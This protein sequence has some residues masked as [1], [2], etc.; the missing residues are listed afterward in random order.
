[1]RHSGGMPIDVTLV[2]AGRTVGALRD[3]SGGVFAAAGDFDRLLDQQRSLPL[4]S[5]IDP[6][7]TTRTRAG[8]MPQL[9]EELTGLRRS[10]RST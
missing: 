7:G 10:A 5:S 9:F 8:D 2:S 4:W 1:M 6:Y 3:P